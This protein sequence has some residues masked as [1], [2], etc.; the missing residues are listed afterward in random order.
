LPFAA[1]CPINTNILREH[2]CITICMGGACMGH[3]AVVCVSVYITGLLGAAIRFAGR[4]KT[5][6]RDIAWR[7]ALWRAHPLVFFQLNPAPL[8]HSRHKGM[9]G[10]RPPKLRMPFFNVSAFRD[11]H[12][13]R[14]HRL[15]PHSVVMHRTPRLQR[16]GMPRVC[17][18]QR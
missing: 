17:V 4:R 11:S 16:Q 15:C 14:V 12:G 10:M 6:D 3:G 9:P 7:L 1:R 5:E 13:L 18:R 8:N 2:I